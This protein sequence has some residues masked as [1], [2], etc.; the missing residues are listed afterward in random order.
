MHTFL[1]LDSHFI[2][3]VSEFFWFDLILV[4]LLTFKMFNF[5]RPDFWLSTCQNSVHDHLF[6]TVIITDVKYNC[7]YRLWVW[8]YPQNRIEISEWTSAISCCELEFELE[9]ELKWFQELEL[10]SNRND[11][12]LNWI[13]TRT[14]MIN[15]SYRTETSLIII[16]NSY[17]WYQQLCN[18]C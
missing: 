4:N 12:F 10:E 14:E 16:K 11:L 18:K 7:Q 5:W 6:F 1:K 9:L 13:V 2:D 17:C 8:E 3:W 15:R